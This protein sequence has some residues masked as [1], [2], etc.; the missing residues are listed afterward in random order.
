MENI[1]D[2]RDAEAE[3]WIAVQISKRNISIKR[4]FNMKRFVCKKC[5]EF[6]GFSCFTSLN[7]F[8]ELWITSQKT[9]V[10]QEVHCSDNFVINLSCSQNEQNQLNDVILEQTS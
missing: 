5:H 2:I 9:I 10:N 8:E 7:P 6:Q 1:R 3:K 4:F